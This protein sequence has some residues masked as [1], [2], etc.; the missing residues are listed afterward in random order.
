VTTN[1]DHRVRGRIRL[2]KASQA[3]SF[4]FRRG[5]CVLSPKDVEFVAQHQDLDLVRLT[6]TQ[7]QQQ[8]LENAAEREI[9]ERPHREEISRVTPMG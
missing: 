2:S 7:T 8:K 5:R 6:S 3:R 1:A 4:G 9:G